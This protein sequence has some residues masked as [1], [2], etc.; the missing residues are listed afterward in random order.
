MVRINLLVK[1]ERPS[2]NLLKI[3]LIVGSLLVVFSMSGVYGYGVFQHWSVTRQLVQLHSQIEELAMVQQK[4][5]KAK[6]AELVINK[7]QKIFNDL[8]RKRVL[9]HI[10]IADLATLTPKNVWL[11]EFNYTGKDIKISGGA[12]S[13]SD[14]AFFIQQ[15]ENDKRVIDPMLDTAGKDKQQDKVNF[16]IVVKTREKE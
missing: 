5:E 14:L 10:F 15:L 13:Y 7:K 4:I 6:Q 9:W 2:D 16:G 3:M 11:N 8:N 1:A 12:V